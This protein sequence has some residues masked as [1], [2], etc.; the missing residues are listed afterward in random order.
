[1]LFHC[2]PPIPLLGHILFS[3]D[4]RGVLEKMKRERRAKTVLGAIWEGMYR[5]AKEDRES[6]RDGAA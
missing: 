4:A 3:L 1:M 5:Y 6:G 2:H